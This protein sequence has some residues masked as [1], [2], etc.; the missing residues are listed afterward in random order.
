MLRARLG[1]IGHGLTRSRIQYGSTNFATVLADEV[2]GVGGRPATVERPIRREE[3]DFRRLD[4]LA[5][6][7]FF[8]CYTIQSATTVPLGLQ[9]VDGFP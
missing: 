7:V 6:A 1:P 2:I 5:A 4:A 8:C 9:T 3:E